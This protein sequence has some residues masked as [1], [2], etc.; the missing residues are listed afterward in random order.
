MAACGDVNDRGVRDSRHADDRIAVCG[1]AVAGIPSARCGDS[2]AQDFEVAVSFQAI[3]SSNIQDPF[4]ADKRSGTRAAGDNVQF[5]AA[6]DDIAI[7]GDPFASD[8]GVRDGHHSGVHSDIAVALDGSAR[9]RIDVAVR[10]DGAPVGGNV[11]YRLQI[12]GSGQVEQEGAAVEG[13]VTGFKALGLNAADSHVHGA[14]IHCKRAITRDAFHIISGARNIDRP[15]VD[16]HV[17]LICI[18]CVAGGGHRQRTIVHSEEFAAMQPV[19]RRRGHRDIAI[20]HADVGAAVNG[21]LFLPRERQ[22]PPPAEDH[23]SRAIKSAFTEPSVG[24]GIA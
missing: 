22:A 14:A 11:L 18:N 12:R 4:F 7:R 23:R 24:A 1:N 3:G 20:E 13:H 6:D 21:V 9:R 16:D 8:S 15:T 10:R 5:P 19:L 2:A 17:P